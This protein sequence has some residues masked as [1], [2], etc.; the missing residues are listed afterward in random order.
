MKLNEFI[1]I[2]KF[3]DKYI[4]NNDSCSMSVITHDFCKLMLDLEFEEVYENGKCYYSVDS[5]NLYAINRFIDF[6]I[7]KSKMDF[8]YTCKYELELNLGKSIMN[9]LFILKFDNGLIASL[10]IDSFVDGIIILKSI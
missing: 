8:K 9:E 1:A 7:D 5:K 4:D 3:I 10:Y 2:P 6:Y